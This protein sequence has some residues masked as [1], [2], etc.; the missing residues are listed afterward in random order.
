MGNIERSL[1]L[2][3]VLFAAADAF[4]QADIPPAAPPVEQEKQQGADNTMSKKKSPISTYKI[5]YFTL[6]NWPTNENAQVKF[7]FSV[8][9]KFFDQDVSVWGRP[10]SLYLAYSQKS[11]WD[12]GQDS[13]PFEET[14]YNPETFLDYAVNG[15]WGPIALRDVIF[16]PFEHESNGLAG[17][18]SRSWNRVYVAIRLGALPITEPSDDDATRRDHV[19]LYLKVWHAYGYSDETAYLQSIG[20]N[21][22]FLNYEGHGEVILSLR[23]ILVHGGWGNRLDITS[24]VGGKENFEFQYE[25]KIPSLNFSPY[26]QY[27]YGYDETLL[28]FDRFGRR[29]FFG[30]SFIY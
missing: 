18:Q 16:S 30:V 23:D 24:R 14:N 26:V 28:R 15:T 4:A 21:E 9:Y 6:N 8:K 11:L 29:A 20:S 2:F 13:S 17:P 25:Q 22:N 5:N 7:Q 1:I 12:V 27:C 10:L 3:I 19:E